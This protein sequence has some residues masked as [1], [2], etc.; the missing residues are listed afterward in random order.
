MSKKNNL[1]IFI[2][3][4]LLVLVLLVISF[5]V[6]NKGDKSSGTSTLSNDPNVILENA[7]KESE[8]ATIDKMRDF[9]EIDSN[10]YLELYSDNK[11][12]VVLFIKT[13]CSFCETAIPILKTI[14]FENKELVINSINISDLTVD[15]RKAIYDSNNYFSTIGTPLLLVVKDNEIVDKIEGLTDRAHYLEF[16]EKYQLIK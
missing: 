6:D 8:S 4:I 15:D 12:S 2:C 13:G 16:F 1:I 14:L 7:T 9:V 10:K 5:N 11:H 3:A